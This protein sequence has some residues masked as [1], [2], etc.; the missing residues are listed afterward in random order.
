MV[1]ANI[2]AP[3]PEKTLHATAAR[4]RHLG[5]TRPIVTDLVKTG[6]LEKQTIDGLTYVWPNEKIPDDEAPRR[7]R[8][9]AP[10]D[11]LVWDRRRFEHLWRWP[12]RFEAYTPA[13]KRLRG[14]Y[15][16]PLLW[17]EAVIG[18]A[19]ANVTARRLTVEVGFVDQRPKEPDFQ[20]ELEAEIG[21]MESFLNLK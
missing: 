13:A 12:Y 18:W 20:I 4:F 1:T 21:R 3:V 6:E 19:N 14:Y 8:F 11:P 16:M 15:A 9:L 5:N 2:L 17:R 10:F 7:V